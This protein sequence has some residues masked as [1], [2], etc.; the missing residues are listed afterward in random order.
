MFLA[1]NGSIYLNPRRVTIK[2][3][4]RLNVPVEQLNEVPINLLKAIK[5]AGERHIAYYYK[6]M[7]MFKYPEKRIK[8]FDTEYYEKVLPL[9]KV[10]LENK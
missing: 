1:N 3:Q 7:S 4:E 2:M 6:T 10:I 5:K 8:T 9:I